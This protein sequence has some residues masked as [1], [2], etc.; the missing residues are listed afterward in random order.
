MRI[1]IIGD[2]HGT[3]AWKRWFNNGV[4]ENIDKVI[5]L[6]D[7]MES[8]YISM[9]VGAFYNNLK[10]IIELKKTYPDKIDLLV[11]N[12]DISYLLDKDSPFQENPELFN[13]AVQYDEIVFSHAGFTK[14]F[15][16]KKGTFLADKQ[17]FSIPR[18]NEVFHK[19]LVDKDLSEIYLLDFNDRC[20]DPTGDNI[21][22]G[23]LWV[24][25]NSLL[26]DAYFPNQVVGHTPT[27]D[28]NPAFLRKTENRIIIV[29]NTA[30]DGNLFLNTEDFDKSTFLTED[31][32][33]KRQKELK[34]L[35]NTLESLKGQKYANIRKEYDLSKKQLAK[36]MDNVKALYELDVPSGVPGTTYL[37]ALSLE[38]AKIKK[39]K[40][41]EVKMPET[42]SIFSTNAR[43]SLLNSPTEQY[44]SAAFAELELG[45]CYDSDK[46]GEIA[47]AL[48]PNYHIIEQDLYSEAY[49][50]FLGTDLKKLCKHIKA[51][52]EK[53]VLNDIS[54]WSDNMQHKVAYVIAEVLKKAR[55]EYEKSGKK[56]IS[57]NFG[58]SQIR[59]CIT[60]LENAGELDYVDIVAYY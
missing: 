3:D 20:L 52:G 11:G 18:I 32:Y 10:E 19:A 9:T 7:Y 44:V 51:D 60:L 43:V 39:E 17:D 37:I 5:F 28:S 30:C 42:K 14:T 48:G 58:K 29:N 38:A 31:K 57:Q 23:P 35:K 21:A 50:T 59:V 2:V 15:V 27:E 56:S 25:P 8:H 1:L 46:S 6:G 16:E 49:I 47:R 40:E 33:N 34:R 55:T 45:D 54:F 41:Q 24:R 26:K 22:Q 36:C 53:V 12:H 13:I 4:P